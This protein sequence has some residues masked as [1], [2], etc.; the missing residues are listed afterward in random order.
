MASPNIWLAEFEARKEGEEYQRVIFRAASE[1]DLYEK[2]RR[3][4]YLKRE[5]LVRVAP[6]LTDDDHFY[7]ED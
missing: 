1:G 3:H 4:H 5:R 7:I 2:I 6:I